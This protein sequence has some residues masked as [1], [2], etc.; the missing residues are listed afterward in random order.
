MIKRIESIDFIKGVAIF[1][2]LL[3]HTFSQS[4]LTISWSALHIGQAVPIFI[5]VT[6][7]LSF[8]SLDKVADNKV[9]S[10]WF[11]TSRVSRM[12]K[13]IIRPVVVVNLCIAIELLLTDYKS[14]IHK[15]IVGG[16]MASAHTIYGYISSF[17]Y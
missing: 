17:G 16:G 6:F 15:L 5:S 3:L 1:S 10:H 8:R 14:L 9:V 11:A 2:V 4:L 13:R 7:F 12:F